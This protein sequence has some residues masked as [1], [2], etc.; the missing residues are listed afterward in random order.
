MLTL[1]PPR[2]RLTTAIPF[3]P[4]FQVGW[5]NAGWHRTEDHDPSKEVQTPH[6]EALIKE[7]CD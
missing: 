5:A 2:A 6:M 3:N 4:T 1:P 7:G